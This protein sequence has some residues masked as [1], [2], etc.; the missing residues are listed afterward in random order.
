MEDLDRPIVQNCVTVKASTQLKRITT[1]GLREWRKLAFGEPIA[2][3]YNPLEYARNP[4]DL[5]LEQAHASVDAVLVG[6][7]P[8]PYGMMQTGVP[9][10]EVSLVKDWLG[11]EA[12]V[13]RPDKEHPKRPVHGF[14]CHRSEVSGRRLWGFFSERFPDAQD[15]FRRFF[16]LNYCPF[17]FFDENGRN[18]TPDK[19]RKADREALF[20]V[21]DKVLRRSVECLNPKAVLG[22]GRFAT[23][24][25]SAALGAGDGAIG[26]LTHPSPANPKANQGWRARVIA[27]F[28]ELGVELP[29]AA[30]ETS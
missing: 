17:L 8:G 25:A 4:Y 13:G 12:P 22:I 1:E 26:C 7:N 3:V 21:C 30:V 15:F 23:D 16:I 10:G 5:Y 11:I 6:M 24:R 19:L 14:A 27:E 29:K 9:F 20:P 2:Y 28:E 18:I